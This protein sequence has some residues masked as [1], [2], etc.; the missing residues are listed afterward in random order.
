MVLTRSMAARRKPLVLPHDM[1]VEIA[2][3][4]AATSSHPMEDICSLRAT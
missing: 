3:H 4:I 2:A 1:V